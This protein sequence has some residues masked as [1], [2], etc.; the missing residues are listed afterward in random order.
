MIEEVDADNL[1][2]PNVDFPHEDTAPVHLH[3]SPDV[4]Q[5]PTLSKYCQVTVEE[6]TD[7]DASP[8]TNNGQYFEPQ[9][10]MGWAQHKGE[11]MFDR[12]RREQNDE[13][14]DAWAPFENM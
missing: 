13:G 9:Q 1:D 8:L 7:E 14:E 6:V 12:Y 10:G 5:N 3:S 4:D 11:T 2:A